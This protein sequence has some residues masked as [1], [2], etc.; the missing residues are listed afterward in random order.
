MQVDRQTIIIALGKREL[1]YLAISGGRW[2]L[3]GFWGSF[4]C[5]K[6]A[7]WRPGR[8]RVRWTEKRPFLSNPLKASP[9][10]ML[11]LLC[12]FWLKDFS[13]FISSLQIGLTPCARYESSHLSGLLDLPAVKNK[14]SVICLNLCR[15]LFTSV[16]LKL[17]KPLLL[18]PP[19]K[20][21]VQWIQKSSLAWWHPHI[22]W[23]AS[24][25]NYSPAASPHSNSYWESQINQSSTVPAV[26]R[27]RCVVPQAWCPL[28]SVC[29]QLSDWC[30]VGWLRTACSGQ[31]GSPP[32]CLT[33]WHC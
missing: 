4:L 31:P 8:W 15:F 20:R 23:G 18:F 19:L 29:T 10:A 26:F 5:S 27:W 14:C 7:A 13:S 12:Y 21:E 32:S 2:A 30:F 25:P 11:T 33:S 3:C 22:H 9:T 1:E 17:G 6:I 28:W 16:Q 24:C